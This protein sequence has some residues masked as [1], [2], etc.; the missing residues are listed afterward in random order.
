MLLAEPA[1]FL[2]VLNRL[3]STSGRNGI[4]FSLFYL[5][6]CHVCS[7]N[8]QMCSRCHSE[9]NAALVTGQHRLTPPTLN[10]QESRI[11]N[12]GSILPFSLIVLAQTQITGRHALV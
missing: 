7:R 11:G 9:V 4:T 1:L 2:P 3:P 5:N 12:K 8:T 10:Y 6:A